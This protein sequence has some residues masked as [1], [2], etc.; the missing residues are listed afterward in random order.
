MQA[1][2]FPS[3]PS[4]KAPL[5]GEFRGGV[6]HCNCRPR[7]P[8]VQLRV[9][10]DGPNWDRPFYKCRRNRN[11][12]NQC[13]FFLW[14]DD[15]QVREQSALWTNSRSEANNTPS[16]KPKRQRTLLE[17][18]TPAKE[19][20]QEKTPVTSIA[21][22]N[23]LLGPTGTPSAT[24]TSSTVKPSSSYGKR[25]SKYLEELFAD[26]SDEAIEVAQTSNSKSPSS[27]AQSMP[28]AGT[29]RK[30]PVDDEEEYS[31]LSSGEEEALAALADGSVKAKGKH[32]DIFKTP[33]TNR[34]LAI[35]AGMP[36]PLTEKPVRRVLF[37][38]P[39]ASA[40]K[41]PLSEGFASIP[42]PTL[43]SPFST[44]SSSQ[45]S[46]ASAST[47]ITQE[48]MSMLEGQKLDA[49]VLRNV[50]G[51]LERHAARAKGLERG[52]D[53]SREAV[54]KAE[55]RAAELQGRVADLENA[56]RLDAEARQKM[57]TDLMKLYRE[58]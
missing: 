29:K 2:G 37:A 44:P 12:D 18:I 46:A 25:T 47:N 22:L 58:S 9:K 8:A 11:E 15:A 54:K 36:T 4:S 13:D 16:R 34:T 23:R 45:Q 39:E 31:D 48:V 27:S 14:A 51:V 43:G 21:E 52:R 57:R 56:R 33:A 24:A 19:K 28:E 41:R 35:E 26:D 20:R 1:S 3:T 50:R 10:K 17:S 38:E 42:A 6:W 32:V 5:N 53:A 55:A 30:R 7:L 49:A 40:S